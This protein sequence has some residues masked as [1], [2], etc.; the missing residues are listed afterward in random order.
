MV[1]DIPLEFLFRDLIIYIYVHD[2]IYIYH[3]KNYVKIVDSTE[4]YRRV[5]RT[6]SQNW[7]QTQATIWNNRSY[8]GKSR[9]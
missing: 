5:R 4:I 2:T 1:F 9:G 7:R 3:E 8:I 6:D